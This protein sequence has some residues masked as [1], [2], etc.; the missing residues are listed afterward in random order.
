MDTALEWYPDTK[1]NG[2]MQTNPVFDP[3]EGAK[4][5]CHPPMTLSI[6]PA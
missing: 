1:M 6:S 4:H 5:R 3:H 2:A